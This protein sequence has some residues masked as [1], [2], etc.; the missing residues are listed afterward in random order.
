[1]SRLLEVIA[2]KVPL[3]A[4]LPP[5]DRIETARGW[6]CAPWTTDSRAQAKA[7]LWKEIYFDA[8]TGQPVDR[9]RNRKIVDHKSLADI[10]QLVRT[11][12]EQASQAE[13]EDEQ[14]ADD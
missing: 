11:S 6:Y 1:M 3:S 13:D 14:V 2:V 5:T 9:L 12:H 10:Q 7:A 4:G 8:R